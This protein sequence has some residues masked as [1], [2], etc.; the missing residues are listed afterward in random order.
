[1]RS[2]INLLLVLLTLAAL[3]SGCDR[4]VCKNTNPLF[5]KF[6]PES[7]EYK[8]ELLKQLEIDDKAELS[9]WFNQYVQ[10]NGQEQLYFNVQGDGLCA[11]IVLNVEEWDKL[12]EVRQKKGM[13]FRGAKFT[14]LTF[15]IKQDSAKIEFVYRDFDK[16]I[17]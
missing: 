4:P 17:D 13:S 8:A 12:E 6:S 7:Q 3:F 5:D 2:K 14:N 1:M 10:S 15:D 9:Y 16:I 11:M